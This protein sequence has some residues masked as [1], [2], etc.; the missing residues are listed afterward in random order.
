MGR[1]SRLYSG[2]GTVL[3]GNLSW[4]TISVPTRKRMSLPGMGWTFR[5]HIFFEGKRKCVDGGVLLGTDPHLSACFGDST[6]APKLGSRRPRRADRDRSYGTRRGRRV[7]R[8]EA[9]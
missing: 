6:Q 3:A 1:M 5:R 4:P 8:V 9:Y 7:S 2:A